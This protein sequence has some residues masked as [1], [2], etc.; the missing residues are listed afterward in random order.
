VAEEVDLEQ[1]YMGENYWSP[2]RRNSA[3]NRILEWDIP[4]GCHS[5]HWRFG[6][7]CGS[8]SGDYSGW[9]IGSHSGRIVISTVVRTV[10]WWGGLSVQGVVGQTQPPMSPWVNMDLRWI[11]G[12]SDQSSLTGAD[13]AWEFGVCWANG[14]GRG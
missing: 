9:Y 2:E 6:H 14:Q 12:A 5:G 13:K 11:Q 3:W 4:L 1:G 10:A 8:S 7:H